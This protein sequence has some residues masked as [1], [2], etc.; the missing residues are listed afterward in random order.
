MEDFNW[1]KPEPS[2]NWS[3][4]EDEKAVEDHVWGRI[5]GDKRG[6]KLT[7]ILECTGVTSLAD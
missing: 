1:L 2:P 4:L 6:M 3:V 7:E 5:L